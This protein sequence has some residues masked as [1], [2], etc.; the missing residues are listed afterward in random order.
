MMRLRMEL[1]PSALQ[2]WSS[3]AGPRAAVERSRHSAAALGESKV[4]EADKL[5][6]LG[7][8]GIDSGSLGIQVVGDRPLLGQG[9]KRQPKSLHRLLRDAVKGSSSLLDLDVVRHQ[10]RRQHPVEVAR[11]ELSPPGPN[12]QEMAVQS[13]PAR[14]RLDVGQFPML[15]SLV[16]STSC[17]LSWISGAIAQRSSSTW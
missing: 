15:P 1:Y 10:L 11:D 13:R 6:L 16:N 17:G 4:Q 8:D 7:D 9:R 5:L 12:D 3:A 14:Q 2:P